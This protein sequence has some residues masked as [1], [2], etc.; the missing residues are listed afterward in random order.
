M[1]NEINGNFQIG[2]R[3]LQDAQKLGP[4]P[5]AAEGT[6]S[7]KDML[8]KNLEEVQRLQQDADVAFERLATGQTSNVTEVLSAVQKAD[9]AFKTLMQMRNK[10]V[11]AWDEIRNMR[12]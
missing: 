3:L 7:F 11:D 6:P 12:I 4:R 10:L 9:L 5:P 2:Q 8:V 1:A